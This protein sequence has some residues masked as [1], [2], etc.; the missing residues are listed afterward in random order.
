MSARS[1][2]DVYDLLPA[3][4]RLRDVE[5]RYP[6]RALL[7]II[8]EQ[9]DIVK[10]DI[11]ALWDDY[12]IETCAEWVIPYIGDLVANNPL[13]EVT[14]RRADVANTIYYRRRKGTLP[15]LEELARN[16]TGWRAH[17]VAFFELLGWTQNL[18][19][20]RYQAAPNPESRDPNA[21]DRVGT[22]NLRSIDALDRLDGPFDVIAHT[23]DVRPMARTEGWYNIRKI[24]FFLWRL[25]RYPLTG[26]SPRRADQPLDYG[27]HFSSLGNPAPLFTDPEREADEAG[28]AREVHVPGPIRPAAFYFDT[29]TYYG[30]GRSIHVVKDGNPV[31]A[32]DIVC[33]D[34]RN[35]DQPPAGK[36]A[37][38]VR[39]GRL[40]FREDEKPDAVEVSYNYGFSADIG[41]G[42]YS[43]L[44]PPP[45]QPE[46]I[47]PD[48]VADPEALGVLIRVPSSNVGTI[49]EALEAWENAARP[50]AVIQIED[51]RTYPE[52]ST[53]NLDG[54]AELVIQAE[55]RKRPTLVGNVTVTGGSDQ[56][57]LVLNGLLIEGYV[58]IEGEL[59]ELVIEHCT[60]VPGRS[61]DEEGT[62]REPTRPSLIVGDTND[63]L[64]LVIDHSIVG[65]LRL[66][67]EMVGLEVGDSIIEEGRA[68]V[69]PALVFSPLDLSSDAPTLHV[70]IG[71]EGPYRAVLPEGQPTTTAAQLRDPLEQAIQDAHESPAFRNTRV[72][73]VPGIERLIVLSGSTDAV[74]IEEDGTAGELGIRVNALVG[75]AL[76]SFSGLGSGEP[77]VTL[78]L[79]DEGPRSIV[80]REEGSEPI[81]TVVRARN[82]LQ[83]AIRTAPGGS[84]A[85][86]DALVGDLGDRLVVLPGTGGV[87]ARFGATADDQTTLLELGLENGH[88]AIAASNGG[89]SPGPPTALRRTTVFGAV[90]VRELSLA[91]EVI[92][93]A[94]VM[95]QRRQAG[96]ARF[97]YVPEESQT[98]QRY[99][100]QPDL[101]LT[102]RAQELGLASEEDLPLFERTLIGTRLR[103]SFTS[104]HYGDPGYAQLG[105]TTAEELRTGAEDGSEMGA[106]SHLKQ[107][108]REANL[109]IR[110][111]EYL[112]FGLEAGLIYVT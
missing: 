10:Q 58:E 82:S 22:V 32:A 62:P 40:A 51:N 73:T 9:A 8:G 63:R 28:L 100:C 1:S 56:A 68:V 110:L 49:T 19:H 65:P 44:R 24:G 30:P 53:I 43:R 103:P 66:P 34:L 23:V 6:L 18:N 67:T 95:A 92:F 71:D 94:P 64:R 70:T 112:P 17:A 14:G 37:V 50:R 75:S 16:V 90:H 79:G 106:F 46:T 80:L 20:L 3:L 105:L 12:F 35:W 59:G 39:L 86:S 104:V 57:R 69:R 42:P 89:E 78:T 81:T 13:Y 33:K 47:T 36:V 91:S 11:D 74:T 2:I 76:P 60:L 85:F 101:A 27:Y 99:R 54:D 87:T 111:E 77:T 84:P 108:Q 88:P 15:M 55:N 98:P 21:V 4:Y 41:G 29:E 109:R 5:Q 97:S 38:D 107:P 52:D 31:P 93:T 7:Q 48:T 83:R 26:I 102:Q 45:D 96:C 61:L 72:I 25:R